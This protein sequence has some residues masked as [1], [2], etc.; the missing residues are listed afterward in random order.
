MCC[1]ITN[2]AH[3]YCCSFAGMHHSFLCFGHCDR[4]K[5]ACRIFST[6][7]IK[8]TTFGYAFGVYTCY[9]SHYLLLM[10][11]SC[12]EYC[13]LQGE[14]EDATL[15]IGGLR[16]QCEG[17]SVFEIAGNRRQKAS[18]AFDCPIENAYCFCIRL[19][20]SLSA[21]QETSLYYDTA[22]IVRR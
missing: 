9:A 15:H 18:N 12:F 14:S 6:A 20:L 21:G 2:V 22:I 8:Q 3:V 7:A 19:R 16:L 10:L 13:P 11:P 17:D 4:I 1:V 5:H